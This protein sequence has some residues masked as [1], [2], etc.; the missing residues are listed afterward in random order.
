MAE[1]KLRLLSGD[2]DDDV[3]TLL[4]KKHEH[5]NAQTIKLRGAVRP[6][7]VFRHFLCKT[8]GFVC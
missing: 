6:K 7:A 5:D 4:P 8:G 1:L 3:L 2:L